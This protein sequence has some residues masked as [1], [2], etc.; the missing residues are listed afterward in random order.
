MTP[1]FARSVRLDTIGRGSAVSVVADEAERVALATR[2]GLEALDRLEG[3][4]TLS[5][6]V[7]GVLATGR[8][9]AAGAQFCVT[10]AEPVPFEQ[11]STV[12]LLFTHDPLP[13]P[14][15]EEFEL[16]KDDLDR[17]EIEGG[18]IDLG[19]ATAQS[20]ALDLDPWPRAPDAEQRRRELGIATEVEASPFAKLLGLRGG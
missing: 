1:E 2:F 17:V 9:R 14:T 3:D 5:P 16:D 19:E 18:A 8:I 10:T 13:E 4:W 6:D 11:D 15:A 12:R 20:M 7:E